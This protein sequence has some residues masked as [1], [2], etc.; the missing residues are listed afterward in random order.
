MFPLTRVEIRNISQIVISSRIKH[1]PNV[2]AFTGCKRECSDREHLLE[3]N[4]QRVAIRQLMA[5]EEKPR[6]RIGF[7]KQ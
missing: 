5:E 2:Y 1:A 3:R 6:P 7:R 4:E